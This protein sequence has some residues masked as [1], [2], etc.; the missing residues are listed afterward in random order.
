MLE[1]WKENLFS[2]RFMNNIPI[3]QRIGVDGLKML[4]LLDF[5]MKW[6]KLSTVFQQAVNKMLKKFK[7]NFK[8]VQK[9]VFCVENPV[10]NPF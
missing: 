6:M 2:N 7:T 9:T 1:K 5:S 10:S 3:E 8:N 4:I